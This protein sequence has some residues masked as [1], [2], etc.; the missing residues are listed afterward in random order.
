MHL[1]EFSPPLVYKSYSRYQI[2]GI[3]ITRLEEHNMPYARAIREMRCGALEGIS[4]SAER[5]S[6]PAIYLFR[7]NKA[8]IIDFILGSHS[9]PAH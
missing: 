4:R 1:R 8:F 5:I 6:Q 7:S 2:A 3:G 9:L